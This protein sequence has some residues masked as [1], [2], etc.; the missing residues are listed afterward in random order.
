M[1]RCTC[2]IALAALIL[3]TGSAEA[4]RFRFVG[5]GTVWTDGDRYAAVSLKD[6]AVRVIDDVADRSWSVTPPDPG[7]YLHEVA[8]R[9]VLWGCSQAAPLL[10]ELGSE[11]T[12]PVPGWDAYLA[13][14]E[15]IRYSLTAPTGPYP[16]GFGRSWLTAA[17]G[18]FRCAAEPSYLDWRTGRL[19][20]GV[21]DLPTKI[22]D[23][24]DPDLEATLCK[25][26]HPRVHHY[27]AVYE[28][29][30]FLLYRHGGQGLLHLSHC[31]SARP[32]FSVRCRCFGPIL[33]HRHLLWLDGYTVRGYDLA[34]RRRV[35]L[36]RLE[37]VAGPQLWATRHTLYVTTYGGY[38]Y[39]AR[40]ERGPT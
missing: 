12:R 8:A 4:G 30:W 6:R 7:C 16:G 40:L 14:F 5:E 19:V 33:G 2:L 17:Y 25:P 11:T 10:Q 32:V 23:L 28:P 22:I 21:P 13:W 26:L 9:N 3:C 15:T 35:S 20:S 24:D 38:V 36:G 39:A 27:V 29:P 1:K 37:P 31:G 34:K 18:C